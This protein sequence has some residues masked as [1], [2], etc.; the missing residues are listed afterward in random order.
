MV[1]AL[2]KVGVEGPGREVLTRHYGKHG[3]EDVAAVKA[4]Y[5]T[6]GLE[7]AFRAYEARSYDTL[8]AWIEEAS[9]AEG[10]PRE[11]FTLLLDKI[12]KRKM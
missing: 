3:E 10:L 6:L 1:Q 2:A 8:K 5:H 9:A 11:V 7:E 4:L 12:Y